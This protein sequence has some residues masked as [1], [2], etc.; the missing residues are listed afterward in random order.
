MA[1]SRKKRKLGAPV[2]WMSQER[3]RRVENLKISGRVDRGKMWRETR[4]WEGEAEERGF[5]RGRTVDPLAADALGGK[6]IDAPGGGGNMK[7]KKGRITTPIAPNVPEG[8]SRD[9]VWAFQPSTTGTV[10]TKR[11]TGLRA[12]E[13][14]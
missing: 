14:P 9:G 2:E 5:G 13:C 3:K 12:K 6:K 1:R 7:L 8:S 4:E 10:Y 11:N